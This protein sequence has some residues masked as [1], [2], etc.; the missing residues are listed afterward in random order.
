MFPLGI[1]GGLPQC[2]GPFCPPAIGERAKP[3]LESLLGASQTQ[4]QLDIMKWAPASITYQKANVECGA[5]LTSRLWRAFSAR[6]PGPALCL[7]L[8]CSFSRWGCGIPATLFCERVYLHCG[9]KSMPFSCH[10]AS[11]FVMSLSMRGQR[12]V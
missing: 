2:C 7:V 3:G 6:C 1:P 8:I 12:D 10:L 9:A 5:L 11:F 4:A